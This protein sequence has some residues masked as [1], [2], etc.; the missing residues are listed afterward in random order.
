VDHVRGAF[1]AIEAYAE[2][3][4]TSLVPDL[5]KIRAG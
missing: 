5:E 2:R 4:A 1:E 3:P